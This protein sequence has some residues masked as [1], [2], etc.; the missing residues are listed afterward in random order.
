MEITKVSDKAFAI[1]AKCD[2]TNKS[3]GITIDPNG[4]DLKMVWSFKIDEAKAHKE[5][6][7]EKKVSGS[8][9]PD[10]NFP[11]CPYCGTK[12]FIICNNCHSISC[13]HG[14]KYF[15]CPVCG[16]SGEVIQVDSIDIKGGGF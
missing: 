6:Y 12:E 9:I 8:L 2:K 5:G 13:Y 4:K 10:T 11:G 7:D 14:D 3:F 1:I 16:I 15:K